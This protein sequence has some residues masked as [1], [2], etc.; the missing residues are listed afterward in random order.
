MK[1]RM[2]MLVI[3]NHFLTLRK[4]MDTLDFRKISLNTLVNEKATYTFNELKEYI[5]WEVK[6]VYF[7]QNCK[8][9]TGQHCHYKE[10][11]MFIM[12]K[13]SCTAIIDQGNG[14]EDVILNGPGD[15]IV[16]GALVW[17]GFKDFSDDALLIALSSTNYNPDRSDYLEDYEAYRKILGENGLAA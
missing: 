15:A 9:A 10:N 6:R 4:H 3:Q 8:E 12:A 14:K 1:H 13:G 5:D 11:E 2:R 17:H 16:T 7:I